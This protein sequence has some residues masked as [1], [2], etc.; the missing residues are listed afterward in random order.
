MEIFKTILPLIIS[1]F[2]GYATNFI[3]VKMLFRP[4]HEIKIFGKRLPFTPGIIP[5]NQ[6][7]LAKE[8]GKAIGNTLFTSDDIK[9]NL[10]GEKSTGTISKGLTSAIF[11]DES[12]KA[13]IE[14][15][16][17][18]E[19][20]SQVRDVIS[21]RAADL[22]ITHINQAD[23]GSII[24]AEAGS[25]IK[26]KTSGTMMAMFVNDELIQSFS[27]PISKKIDEYMDTTGSVK[28]SVAI[29]KEISALEN[30]TTNELLESSG[31]TEQTVES[32][33]S[34]MI[35]K[36]VSTQLDQVLESLDIPSV[37][38]EKVNAMDV[39]ELEDLV[40]SVMKTELNAIV[41]LGALIGLIIGL[42]NLIL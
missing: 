16:S 8:I 18:E 12:L 3:A 14:K 11:S 32:A 31:I 36:F 9:E 35:A 29:E 1:G 25:V 26:E 34:S 7:R 42:L 27:H 20:Y 17:G 21:Q 23:V 6:P 41:N 2:I 40:M 4:R 37:V 30:K 5:K 22:I 28:I 15:L 10:I 39:A 38:E 13:Q 24:I 19:K 33:I